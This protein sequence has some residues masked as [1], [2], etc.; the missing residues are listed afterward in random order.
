MADIDTFMPG[1][2][3]AV[4]GVADWFRSLKDTAETAASDTGRIERDSWLA[5]SGA[6]GDA[7]R[8]FNR[9]LKKATEEVEDRARDA[10]DKVRSYAQQLAWRQQDMA[11]HRTTAREGG[12]TVIDT[13]IKAPP[14]PV[15]PGDLPAGS[16]QEEADAWERKNTAFEAANDK[17]DLYNELLEDVRGTFDDLDTWVTENLV[18]LEKTLSSPFT[19]TALAGALAGYGLTVPENRFNAQARELRSSA[20]RAAESLAARRSGNPAVRSGSKPPRQAS[21]D[22]ASKPGTR[23]GNLLDKAG[24][25]ARW[26]KFFARSNVVT[27]LVLGGWEIA[28]GKSPSS[29]IVETGASMAAGA[30]VAALVAAGVIT[31]PAWGTAAIVVGAGAV[32]AAGAGW[33]YE[34]FVPQAT[35]EKIDEGISDAWDATGGKVVDGIG[36]AWNSVFG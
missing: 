36:D 30:G 18:D 28:N 16:T 7:Y 5:W 11:G 27:G 35:R 32:A 12:L 1:D 31:A 19:I 8:D 2:P 20:R 10:Q 15:S 34:T 26:A 14:T 22:K 24:G 6:D 9:D 21:I 25:A 4:H 13:V 17:V 29:V 23:A 3:E 33:A